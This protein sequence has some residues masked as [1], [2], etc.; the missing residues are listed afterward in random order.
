MALR[1]V[2]MMRN[3]SEN[4]WFPEIIKSVASENKGVEEIIKEIFRHKDFLISAGKLKE[5]ANRITKQESKKLFT[6]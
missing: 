2:L 3:Q 1:T 5:N 6:H 4:D